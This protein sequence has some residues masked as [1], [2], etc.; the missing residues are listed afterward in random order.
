MANEKTKAVVHVLPEGRAIN[1]SLFTRDI[2]TDEAGKEGKP[3]YKAEVAFGPKDVTGQGTIE[4]TIADVIAGEWGEAA[5]DIFLNTGSNADGSILYNSPFLDGNDLAQKRKEKGKDGTAYEGKL[6]LRC[7]TLYN[8]NGDEDAGGIAVYG[9]DAE[10]IEPAGQ[11]AV[12][13]GCYGHVA[14]TFKATEREVPGGRGKTVKVRGV[15]AFLQAFQV[16]DNDEKHKLKAA[17][18]S[19]FKPVGRAPA[20]AGGR[21]TRAG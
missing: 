21:R 8:K 10:P 1:L 6:V 2:Y 11:S 16:T 3:M 18:A 14:V 17:A 13:N 12:F 4:D 15:K 20:A 7:N 5:A 9:A 19:P